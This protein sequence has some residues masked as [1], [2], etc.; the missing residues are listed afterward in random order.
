MPDDLGPH[1]LKVDRRLFLRG[2][3]GALLAL[4][5]LP[6]LL[7]S[8]EAKAQAAVTPKCFVHY[9]TPHGGVPE[10]H[11]YP[12]AT[13]LTEQMTYLHDIRRG[14]LAGPVSNANAVISPVLTA[15]ATKLTPALISKMNV[16][17]GLDIAYDIQHNFGGVCG[18]YGR[19]QQTAQY[20]RATV[21]QLIAYS[22]VVY[23]SVST[24][25]RRSV[26]VGSRFAQSG[27]YGFSTPGVRSSGVGGQLD[28]DQ[29]SL[30]LFNLL[31]GGTT[32][33]TPTPR[34]PV[35]D[36]VLESYRRL[37]TG[38]KRLSAEDKL[39]LDQH[40]TAVSE[41]Q[42]RLGTGVQAGCVVP[43]KPTVD[44]DTLAGDL[45]HRN[46]DGDPV[47][48]VQFFQLINDVLAVAMN[49]GAT[50]VANFQV[51]EDFM[52]C[53]FTSRAAQGQDWHNNVA[54]SSAAAMLELVRQSNQAFFAGVFVDMISRLNSFSDG[55]GG[56]LLDHSLVAW[57]QENG[58]NLHEGIGMPVVM[59]G[60]AG[61]AIKTGSFCDYRNLGSSAK[62]GLTYNQWLTTAL[63]AM[64]VPQA[65]WEES[66]AH[67]VSATMAHPGY[68][69]KQNYNNWYPDP[70]WAKTAEQLPWL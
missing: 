3:G 39:R 46:M 24:V 57:G 35:V 16:L 48:N 19:D 59:A 13:A 34:A 61:G 63:R 1:V 15:P 64:G 28:M 11:M 58:I 60:S 17:R 62:S 65:D 51:N 38:T 49:C 4:P 43:P 42:R 55:M 50:R 54:H 25:K 8:S 32:S 69:V 10:A 37:R 53:T 18:Y 33:T 26:L 29:S 70:I 9:R 20:P 30:D 41:L 27:W 36:R 2:V 68:G 67:G 22:P 44:S 7:S 40:I 45:D 52:G 31:L 14:A 6:S 21:D 47:K 66:T 56:T 5:V 23:P 12:A